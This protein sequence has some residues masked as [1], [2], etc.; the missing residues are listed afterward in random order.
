[1]ADSTLTIRTD[2]E[3]KMKANEVFSSLGMS[4]TTAI[5][6]F[7]KQAVIKRAFPCSLELENSRDYEYEYPEGFFG[8]FGEG[9]GLGF[10]ERPPQPMFT[11]DLQREDI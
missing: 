5:N 3:L 6:L 1:M 7:L 4:M 8:L 11:A 2:E 10:D 9:N